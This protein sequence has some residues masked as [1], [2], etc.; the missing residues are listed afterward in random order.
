M[1]T[2]NDNPARGV[3]RPRLLDLFCGEGGCSV[4]YSKAGFSPYGIDND[5]KP[6]RH[7]P[8]PHICMDALE[9]MD[10]LL[11]GEGLTF[12]N[13]ETLYLVDFA[14]LHASP[15][16]Q[17]YTRLRHL[18]WLVNRVYWRS[19]PPTRKR[20]ERAG[21]PWVMENVKD[22]YDLPDSIILDGRMFG[23]PIYRDRRFAASFLV[24]APKAEK[25]TGVCTPGHAVMARR[26]AA[27]DIAVIERR[28][29]KG[30]LSYFQQVSGVAGHFT[31][32]QRGRIATG[33]D[34]MSGRGL[35]QSVP[36]VFTEYIG[37][38]LLQVALRGS[39]ATPPCSEAIKP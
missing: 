36:W 37:R 33:N 19:V 30:S 5:P 35:S 38:Y 32:V 24:L 9:A 34:W 26:Y 27:S 13:G 22:C 6:L 1:V 7:Y 14:A 20:L 25:R 10:R 4:G 17:Y 15:P 8:F 18:P 2:Q 3:E 16:C 28:G 23:L 12:S 29:E 31:G 11:K 39:P 21:I